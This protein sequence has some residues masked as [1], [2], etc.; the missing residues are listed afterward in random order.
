MVATTNCQTGSFSSTEATSVLGVGI[1]KI[2]S[3]LQKGQKFLNLL[4]KARE[5]NHPC[6]SQ[7]ARLD[8][9]RLFCKRKEGTR[10]LL[11]ERVGKDDCPVIVRA[12]NSCIAP[13]NAGTRFSRLDLHAGPMPLLKPVRNMPQ[14][15]HHV[16]MAASGYT[17][18]PDVYR[19]LQIS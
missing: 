19:S 15:I 9:L 12:S 16:H 14:R 8:G 13:V 2:P 1:R 6:S 3:Y 5:H 11:G 7:E 18:N 17:Q 4:W 10:Y